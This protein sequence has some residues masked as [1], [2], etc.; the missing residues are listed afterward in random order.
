MRYAQAL[1]LFIM[2]LCLQSTP[3]NAA[4]FRFIWGSLGCGAGQFNHPT[5]VATDPQ[6]NIYVSDTGNRRIQKFTTSGE[7]MAG[8]SGRELSAPIGLAVGND[9]LYVVDASLAHVLV[10]TLDGVL[11]HAWGTFGS[12]PGQFDNPYGIA[13]GPDGCVYVADTGNHRI[14]KFGPDGAFMLAWGSSGS[15]DGQ[16]Q[17]PCGIAI[18]A[19]GLISISDTGN[20]QIQTFNPDGG[21]LATWGTP[22]GDIWQLAYPVGIAIDATGDRLVADRLS[23]QVK[24]FTAF[25]EWMSAWGSYGHDSGQFDNPFGVAVSPD[26]DVYVSDRNNH[27]IEVFGST[28]TPTEKLTWG[29]LKVNYRK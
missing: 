27:R 9:R 22:G 14:Q 29:S 25:G 15:M 3:V 8:W 11:I 5:G 23:H 13:V 17:S 4:K 24:Q 6:G 7:Y 18:D 16:F 21:M 28:T 20:G 19:C 2:L 10:Y 26:G 12:C 1:F